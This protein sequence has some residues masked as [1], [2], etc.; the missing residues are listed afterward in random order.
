MKTLLAII[1]L[2]IFSTQ[3]ILQGQELVT[4]AAALAEQNIEET[5]SRTDEETGYSELTEKLDALKHD[6]VNLNAATREELEQLAILNDFQV[7]SLLDYRKNFGN[8]ASLNELLLVPGFT[9][10]S[11]DLLRPYTVTEEPP[12][13]LPSLREALQQGNSSLMTRVQR[14]LQLLAGE[15]DSSGYPGIPAR[16]YTRYAYT[17]RNTIRAGFT[18]EKD[19]GEA[20]PS[21]SGIRLMDFQSA[22][23]QLKNLGS[24]KSM[25]VGDYN[26]RFG[27][28]LVL[29]SGYAG[30]K[31]SDGISIRKRQDGISPYTSTDENRFFRGAASTLQVDDTEFSFFFS[32]KPVDANIGY[33]DSLL[34]KPVSFSSFRTDGLHLSEQDM[35]EKDAVDEMVAGGNISV[36]KSN[37]RWGLTAVH[38]RYSSTLV[39]FREGYSLFNPGGNSFTTGGI[40]FQ[41]RTGTVLFFG[42]GGVASTGGFSFLAGA[43]LHPS[44]GFT[45]SFLT[46]NMARKFTALYGRPFSESGKC[47]NEQGIYTGFQLQ[48]PAHLILSG[49]YDLYRFPWLRYNADAPSGGEELLVKLSWNPS[50]S[51]QMQM[52]YRSEK[53]QVNSDPE[54]AGMHLLGESLRRSFRYAA[55]VRLNDAWRTQSRVDIN[56]PSS[57]AGT[58][59]PGYLLSQDLSWKPMETK[60]ALALRYALFDVDSYENRIYSYE[61]DLLYAF[62]VPSFYGRGTRIYALV[63]CTFF[64]RIDLWLRMARTQVMDRQTMGSGMSMIEGNRRTDV[65]LQLRIRF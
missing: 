5:I 32:M 21:G 58:D 49:F 18:A 42:E 36:N 48:L 29:W 46:R 33:F 54:N 61:S 57:G 52:R 53:N 24:I 16:I 14:P 51:L 47:N 45:L 62:S 13:S 22:F 15:L 17:Y 41:Y 23:V 30:G 55:L 39:P 31:N 3:T 44:P 38:T 9:E 7:F 43:L 4:G 40:D 56:I 65:G 35:R 63:S 6:Q 34:M 20:F 19:A 28:G 10:E 27:Q 11:I 59:R 1:L 37:L 26:L 60:V 2:F 8:L 64:K 12:Q 25:V 50:L